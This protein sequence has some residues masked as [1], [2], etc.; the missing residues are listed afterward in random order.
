MIDEFFNNNFHLRGGDQVLAGQL[1]ISSRQLDR[2]LKSLYGKSYREKLLE[3]RLEVS[4]DLLKFSDKSV[5]SISELTGYS[6][7]ASFCSFIKKETGHTPGEIR[8]L[9]SPVHTPGSGFC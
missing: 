4:L 7:P 1:H 6:N 2:I 9:T 5:A 3:I 8:R